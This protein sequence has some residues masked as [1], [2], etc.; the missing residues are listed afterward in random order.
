MFRRPCG[1]LL[2]MIETSGF[3]DFGSI[4]VPLRGLPGLS[5]TRFARPYLFH[6]GDYT[7]HAVLVSRDG[8]STWEHTI[9]SRQEADAFLLEMIQFDVDPGGKCLRNTIWS[10]VRM[11]GKRP[12]IDD[13]RKDRRRHWR[14][15]HMARLAGEAKTIIPA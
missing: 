14:E 8:G 1:D 4:P 11:W 7:E 10:Q 12:W 13:H 5:E 15:Q 3:T 6:D 2:K 9:I